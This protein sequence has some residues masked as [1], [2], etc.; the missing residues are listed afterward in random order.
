MTSKTTRLG[1]TVIALSIAWLGSGAEAVAQ[2]PV[3]PLLN[4]APGAT[5]EDGDACADLHKMTASLTGASFT[6]R[7]SM[8][9]TIRC[10][11]R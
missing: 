11:T 8:P 5:D 9:I 2:T 7:A 4:G 6:V 1:L 3:C 10:W